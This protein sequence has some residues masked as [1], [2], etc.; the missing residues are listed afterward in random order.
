MWEYYIVTF[1]PIDSGRKEEYYYTNI[2]D[3]FKH[4]MLFDNNDSDIF[5]RIEIVHLTDNKEEVIDCLFFE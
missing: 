1:Y 5:E 4:F 3:A 2:K